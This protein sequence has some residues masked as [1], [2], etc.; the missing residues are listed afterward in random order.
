MYVSDSPAEQR[1]VL[2]KKEK[3]KLVFPLCCWRYRPSKPY[4]LF[5]VKW[6]VMQVSP[7]L[8]SGPR[9]DYAAS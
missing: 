6:S 3:R 2:S 5:V 4:F 9:I 8:L 7:R 1:E